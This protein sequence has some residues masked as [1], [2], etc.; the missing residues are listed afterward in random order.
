MRLLGRSAEVWRCG[1]RYFLNSH[2]SVDEKI[3]LLLGLKVARVHQWEKLSVLALDHL[4]HG[5]VEEVAGVKRL[6]LLHPVSSDG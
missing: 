4:S 2:C 1:I 6:L 3:L 5:L